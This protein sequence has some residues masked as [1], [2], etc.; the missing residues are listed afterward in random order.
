MPSAVASSL[1]RSSARIAA[2]RWDRF[3]LLLPMQHVLPLMI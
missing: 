2:C 1:P 3:G